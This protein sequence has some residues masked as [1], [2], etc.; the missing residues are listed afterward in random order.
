MAHRSAKRV[1]LGSTKAL[2]KVAHVTFV[3]RANINRMRA[4]HRVLSA[5]RGPKAR[6]ARLAVTNAQ[7]ANTV[8]RAGAAC[9]R[10]APQAPLR[11]LAASFF[12][13]QLGSLLGRYAVGYASSVCKACPLGQWQAEP[14]SEICMATPPG[15][16][17][18]SARSG[19]A[20]CAKGTYQSS[21]NMTSCKVATGVSGSRS[22]P[23]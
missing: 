6:L 18:N 17:A 1:H 7:L 11:T 23:V 22:E 10:H 19:Y 2:Q 5:L 15:H 3:Q 12:T 4:P 16:A 8:A 20:A 9:A 14:A 21:W 13:H